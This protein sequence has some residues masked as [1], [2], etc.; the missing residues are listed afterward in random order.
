MNKIAFLKYFLPLFVFLFA[1]KIQAQKVDKIYITDGSELS[2]NVVSTEGD[3]I[4]YSAYFNDVNNTIFCI[5]KTEVDR[6]SYKNGLKEDIS[7]PS[8]E[9]ARLVK[10]RFRLLNEQNERTRDSIKARLDRHKNILKLSPFTLMNGYMVV[11]YERSIGKMQ[12]MEVK[13][14]II[15]VK[16][17]FDKDI[18]PSG[19]FASLSYKLIFPPDEKQ[20]HPRNLLHGWYLNPE[21]AIGSYYHTFTNEVFRGKVKTVEEG[22][23]HISYK[24]GLLNAGKQWIWGSFV[25]DV[26]VGL[27]AGSYKQSANG[28]GIVDRTRYAYRMDM[29]GLSGDSGV[30]FKLGLYMGFLF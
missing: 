14:G 25:F 26:F 13:I 27:G 6:I 28:Y 2:V 15:G 19:A 7:E 12:S 4:R 3:S 21:L 1:H 5:R 30:K 23:Q 18:P 8:A 16:K 24:C 17:G 20:K 9:N 29:K 22:K 11:G 10:E